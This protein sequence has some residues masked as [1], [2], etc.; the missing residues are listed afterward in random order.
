MV[1]TNDDDLA[2]KLKFLRS[3][4]QTG[5]YYHEMLG[6]NYRMTDVEA[7]IGR[8]QL[9]RLDQMLDVRR[10]NKA[11]FDERLGQMNGVYPQKQTADT[12]HAV[13]LYCIRIVPEEFGVSRDDLSAALM[14][15]E[16]H[17]G[18]HYPRGLHQ[19]PVFEEM[20]GKQSLPATEKLCE[21]IIAIPVHH[22]LSEDD[23]NAV[24]DAI[25]ECH[26]KAL[27]KAA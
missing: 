17:N 3:H 10:R 1:C 13:H 24:I 12:T 27:N 16:I 6:L 2:H 4:G 20:Y 9:G 14:E 25:E 23:A 5:K 7:A 26:T 15:K 21:E 18:V 22:G 8:K 19:Q 11:I